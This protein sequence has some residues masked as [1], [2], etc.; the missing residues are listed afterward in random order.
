MRKEKVHAKYSRNTGTV[1]YT[2]KQTN[3]K[4]KDLFSMPDRFDAMIDAIQ[5]PDL[6]TLCVLRAAWFCKFNYSK[7]ADYYAYQATPQEQRLFEALGLVLLDRDNA[8]ENGFADLMLTV[9][10]DMDYPPD[11]PDMEQW[12]GVEEN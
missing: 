3:H 8:I 7:I 11:Y 4:I 9:D 12:D 1:Q 10:S 5:D 6:Q 2:P